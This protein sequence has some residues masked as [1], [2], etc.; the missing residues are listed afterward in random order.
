MSLNDKGYKAGGH[1]Q[2]L[3]NARIKITDNGDILVVGYDKYGFKREILNPYHLVKFDTAYFQIKSCSVEYNYIIYYKDMDW[4]RPMIPSDRV[5]KL[6]KSNSVW[7]AIYDLLAES[8][9][10][11]C[12]LSGVVPYDKLIAKYGEDSYE[13]VDLEGVTDIVVQAIRQRDSK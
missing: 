2:P 5:P 7:Y 13:A 8:S 11:A 9:L 10:Y 3:T 12:N 1:P 6:P 4:E